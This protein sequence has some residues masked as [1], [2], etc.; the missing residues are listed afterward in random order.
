MGQYRCFSSLARRK[1]DP[2]FLPRHCSRDVLEGSRKKD[3][4]T[5]FTQVAK[6][7]QKTTIAYTIPKVLEAATCILMHHVSAG[8]KLYSDSPWTYTRCQEFYN[9]QNGWKLVVGGFTP[10]GL[11]VNYYFCY[12]GYG[13]EHFGVGVGRKF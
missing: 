3:Y 10:D 12:Y 2:I 7:A 1:S 11:C 8:Q 4:K 6:L 9:Q 13:S 5:Q